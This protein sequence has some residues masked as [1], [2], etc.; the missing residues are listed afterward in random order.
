MPLIF[1]VDA[2]KHELEGF[3]GKNQLESKDRSRIVNSNHFARLTKLLDEDKVSGKIVHG[4]ERDK[5]NL[6]VAVCIFLLFHWYSFA[7]CNGHF[8]LLM[9]LSSNHRKIAPTI[10]LDVPRDSLI[11]NE[12]IFGPL[13]PIFT[14][15]TKIIDYIEIWLKDLLFL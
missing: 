5:A 14:V 1:Q 13:L 3:Y 2:L 12:E 10:L 6:W 9:L 15:G 4:G 8:I 7:K 11:M